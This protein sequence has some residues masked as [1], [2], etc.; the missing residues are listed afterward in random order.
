MPSGAGVCS[1]RGLAGLLLA[2]LIASD[3]ALPPVSGAREQYEGIP[4]PPY[5]FYEALLGLTEARDFDGLRRAVRHLEPLFSALRIRFGRDMGIE[6]TR[7]AAEGDGSGALAAVLRLILLDMRLNLLEA[8]EAGAQE[9]EALVQMAYLNYRFLAERLEPRDRA[10]G[11][12]V[13][14]AFKAAYRTRDRAVFA[15]RVS[16]IMNA[17]TPD[18]L[19]IDDART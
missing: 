17:V 14:A 16:E 4:L 12:R 10:L 1:R 15:A 7:A 19:G 13:R 3:A 8:L 5:E 18:A 6:I 9:R 11:A 2:G